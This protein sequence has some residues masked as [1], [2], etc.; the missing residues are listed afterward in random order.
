MGAL[1]RMPFFVEPTSPSLLIEIGED[2]VENCTF[3]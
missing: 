2:W 3:L 1:A